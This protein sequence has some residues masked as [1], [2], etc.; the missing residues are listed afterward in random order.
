MEYMLTLL[1]VFLATLCLHF[2]FNTRLYA[3]HKHL[4]VTVVSLFCVGTLWDF[5]AI[6]RGHW[7][8]PPENLVG[9]YFLTIPLEEYIFFFVV[10]YFILTVFK[11]AELVFA[12]ESDTVTETVERLKTVHADSLSLSPLNLSRFITGRVISVAQATFPAI[13]IPG[14]GR[15]SP[16]LSSDHLSQSRQGRDG[17]EEASGDAE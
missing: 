15:F 17:R 6:S 3:N 11:V 4:I 5:W 10:P 14:A 8:F 12:E 9:I 1:V 2:K 13:R 7:T 16:E